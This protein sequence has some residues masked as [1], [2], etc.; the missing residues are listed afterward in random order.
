M[1]D[2]E[3]I[4][5]HTRPLTGDVL[6][7]DEC[8]TIRIKGVEWSVRP[9]QL[10]QGILYT[11]EF[12]ESVSLRQTVDPLGNKPMQDRA[13]ELVA[14]LNSRPKGMNGI[15]AVCIYLGE[16]LDQQYDLAP[17]V[18]ADLLSFRGDEPPV[19]YQQTIRHANG[20]SPQ[21][22]MIDSIIETAPEIIHAEQPEPVKHS[23]WKFWD[24]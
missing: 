19:W 14:Y 6:H 12:G 4:A 23:W 3:T 18:K 21:P 24:K 22:S 1:K 16:L 13:G 7:P 9:L 15:L 2:W 5:A 17:E 10:P 11:P 8:V 20:L